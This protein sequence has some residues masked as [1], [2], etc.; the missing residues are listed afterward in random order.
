MEIEIVETEHWEETTDKKISYRDAFP[1]F[2]LLFSFHMNNAKYQHSRDA[3][4]Y[5]SFGAR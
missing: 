2:F 3:E 5:F 1:S 4:L